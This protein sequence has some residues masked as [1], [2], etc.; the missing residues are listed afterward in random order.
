MAAPFAHFS[1]RRPIAN[2]MATPVL[3]SKGTGN[4][5]GQQGAR[6]VFVGNFGDC[7][8][9]CELRPRGLGKEPG[10][11]TDREASGLVASRGNLENLTGKELVGTGPASQGSLSDSAS[12]LSCSSTVLSE[13]KKP[14]DPAPPAPDQSRPARCVE[15]CAPCVELDKV[16][17]PLPPSIKGIKIMSWNM[18]G[19]RARLKR[20]DL[21]SVIRD[22][23]ADVFMA[24]EF[25]Y[26]LD[27][28][29]KRPE[30]KETLLQMGYLYISYHMSVANAG[31]AGVVIFSRIRFT[32]FGEGV[33]DNDLDSEGRVAWVEFDKFRL[34]NIYAPNSG[35]V[36]NLSSMPKKLKFLR[37]LSRKITNQNKSFLLC[38]DFNVTRL[39]SDVYDGLDHER[40]RNHPSCTL[41]ER[42]ALEDLMAKSNLV[43]IQHESKVKGYTFF[44]RSWMV[45]QNMGMR[46]DYSLCDENF[47]KEHVLKFELLPTTAGSDHVP[48]VLT[49]NANVFTQV[50]LGLERPPYI[51]NA[52]DGICSLEQVLEKPSAFAIKKE[53]LGV[54]IFSMR[55][56]FSYLLS[57]TSSQPGLVEGFSTSLLGCRARRLDPDGSGAVNWQHMEELF[58]DTST[59]SHYKE[60]TEDRHGHIYN[61]NASGKFT[62]LPVLQIK[63]SNSRNNFSALADS[64]ASA[65]I[66]YHKGL[67]KHFGEEELAKR[68]V[69]NLLHQRC[70]VGILG[71][72]RM[73]LSFHTG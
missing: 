26:S 17:S 5:P 73:C 49:L 65:S 22:K 28:F 64:G 38:G 30:V 59:D 40:W 41:E 32:G 42:T 4:N 57:P 43:D 63:V 3:K 36:N 37:A 48:S 35:S 6:P 62:I 72:T 66:A 8:W 33:G 51:L 20:S 39:H 45:D 47:F 13:P 14:T 21:L 69:Q 68:L 10:L 50:E 16:Q 11:A 24:Q 61:T 52:P 56:H 18:N 19:A 71:D 55:H 60:D 54:P 58:N 1:S 7:H 12:V 34:Y 27:V 31:Y 9:N 25:R 15:S 53:H 67:L 29:L 2:G 46:V 44:R 23:N 70:A